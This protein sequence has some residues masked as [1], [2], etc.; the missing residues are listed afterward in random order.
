MIAR[1]PTYHRLIQIA[2]RANE[3]VA[4]PDADRRGRVRASQAIAMCS[5]PV[6]FFGDLPPEVLRDDILDGVRRLFDGP[7]VG[8]SGTGAAPARRRVGRPRAMSSGQVAAARRMHA[9][10]SHSVEEIAASLGV[11]RATV[12]RHLERP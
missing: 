12:Y 7:V 4:G 2:L 9:T 10:G 11:S 3:I 6:M 8:D 5:D 1:G